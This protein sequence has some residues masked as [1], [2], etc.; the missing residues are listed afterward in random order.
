M[1]GSVKSNA[2]FLL[3]LDAARIGIERSH[4]REDLRHIYWL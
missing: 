3:A 4:Q 1:E 2:D